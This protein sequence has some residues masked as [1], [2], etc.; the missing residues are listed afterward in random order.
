MEEDNRFKRITDLK[1]INVIQPM[2]PL[3]PRL[4]LQSLYRPK[5]WP[6][7]ITDLKDCFFTIHLHE[8]DRKR[9]AFSVPTLNNSHSLEITLESTSTGNV[10]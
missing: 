6:R 3:Q 2:G 5:S 10:K 8:Q 7:K 4:P 1:A 9:F